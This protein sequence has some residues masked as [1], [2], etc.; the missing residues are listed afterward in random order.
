MATVEY[1]CELNAPL[2]RVWAFYDT[3]ESLFKVT[4]PEIYARLDG[5]ALPMG[6]GVVYHLRFSRF[7]IP[8][9]LDSKIVVYEPPH[10]FVDEQI[11]GPFHFWRHIHQFEALPNSRTRLIDH[12]QYTLPFGPFGRFADLLFFRR[13]VNKMFAYRHKITRENVEK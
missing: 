9:R 10:R 13:E 6:T 5:P 7:G 3:V 11:K 12:I 1:I 2:E 4:P 8:M